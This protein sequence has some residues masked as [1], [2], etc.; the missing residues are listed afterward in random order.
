MAAIRRVAENRM[1]LTGGRFLTAEDAENKSPVCV[2]SDTMLNELG[3][4]IG[5]TI[6]LR[7]GDRLMEQYAPLGAVASTRGRYA[8]NFTEEQEFEIV[9]SYIEISMNK[10]LDVDLCWAY[11]DNTVFVPLSFLPVNEETLAEHEFKPSDISFVISDASNIRAFYDEQIPKLQEMGY[12]VHF[13]DNGWMNIEQYLTRSNVLTVSK[14]IAFASAAL[15]S[16]LLTV[17]L[18][19]VR[20]KREFAIMR[21]LGTARPKARRSL[22]IPLMLLAATATPFILQIY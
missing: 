12:Q 3:L 13:S 14:L 22:L 4:E 19:I 20:K 5:D 2:V 1:L 16:S 9:G 15:L 17:Y 10:M 11:S 8:E 6:S 21:A 18:F 7:L